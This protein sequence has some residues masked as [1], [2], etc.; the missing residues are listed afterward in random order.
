M[1]GF[2]V[3][4]IFSTTIFDLS[5]PGAVVENVQWVTINVW[6]EDRERYSYVN[7]EINICTKSAGLLKYCRMVEQNII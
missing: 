4:P 5:D 7:V 2:I 3:L 1:R 6:F